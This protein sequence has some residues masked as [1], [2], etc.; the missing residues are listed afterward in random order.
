[1][2][3]ILIA[4]IGVI[5]TILLVVG[6]HE[7]GHFILARMTGVKVLRFSIGFGKA[8]CRWH[9]KKGTEYVIAAVPL[10]GYVKLLDE[11]EEDVPSAEKHLA[12]NNQPFYKKF[13]IIAAGPAF[14]VIFAFLLYW[15]LFMIGFISLVPMIGKITPHSIAAQAGMQPQQEIVRIDDRHTASWMSVVIG[16]LE[17]TGDK[18]PLTIETKNPK[19]QALHPYSLDLSHWHMDDLKPDPLDSLGIV[20]FA[21]DKPL[22]NDLLKKNKYGPISALSHAWQNTKDFCYLNLMVFGKLVTG[23][24]SLSSLGGPITIFESAGTAINNGFVPFLSFLAFLSIAIGLINIVPIPGLDGG[25]LLF[26]VIE[27]MIRRPLPMRAQV[28]LFRIGFI[29]ILLLVTQALI[30]DILR[31]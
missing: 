15:S 3:S 5:I 4:I 30:N 31:L 18:G 26:Q 8:L 29:L 7:F 14:N 17:R 16:L 11:T 10:G 21:P 22:S 2:L 27:L 20:P 13:L 12:F 23:K 24:V 25:L 9:D 1:M 19:T 6:V 28:L